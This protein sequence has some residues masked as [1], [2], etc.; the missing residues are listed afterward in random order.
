LRRNS[1]RDYSFKEA[2]CRNSFRP[3]NAIA[4]ELRGPFHVPKPQRRDG[5]SDCAATAAQEHVGRRAAGQLPLSE[6]ARPPGQRR[7]ASAPHASSAAACPQLPL[8]YLSPRR[9]CHTRRSCVSLCRRRDL[10]NYAACRRSRRRRFRSLV[11]VVDATLLL[12]ATRVS[13]GCYTRR[14][15]TRGPP[16]GHEQQRGSGSA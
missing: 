16:P 15:S 12:P 13:A 6:A 5:C 4:C 2:A 8:R 1:W 7:A 11:G 14:R 9:V 10:F 3:P